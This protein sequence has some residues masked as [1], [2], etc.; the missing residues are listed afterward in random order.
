MIVILVL[1]SYLC[2]NGENLFY[3]TELLLELRLWILRQKNLCLRIVI[4]YK[5][6]LWHSDSQNIASSK[7]FGIDIDEY[8]LDDVDNSCIVLWK[9]DNAKSLI[10]SSL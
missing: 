3:V 2:W 7:V 8:V 5:K 10:P 9:D 6:C 4:K 1:S